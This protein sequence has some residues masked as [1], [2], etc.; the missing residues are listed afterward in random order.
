MKLK[1][2]QQMLGGNRRSLSSDP[3]YTIDT[4]YTEP[5]APLVSVRLRSIKLPHPMRLKPNAFVQGAPT[6]SNETMHPF[7]I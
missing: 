5:I 6:L 7:T 3:I 2:E 4:V 1:T